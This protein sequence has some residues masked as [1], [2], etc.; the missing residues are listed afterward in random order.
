MTAS[1]RALLP[2]PAAA[3]LPLGSAG[4]DRSDALGVASARGIAVVEDV[5]SWGR[6]VSPLSEPEPAWAVAV[7]PRGT[8]VAAVAEGA[9]SPERAREQ[10]LARCRRGLQHARPSGLECALYSL[11]GALRFRRSGSGHPSVDVEL[12]PA[13]PARPFGAGDAL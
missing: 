9:D 1:A 4:D 6:L 12:R 2:L 8:G 11:D 5:R 10:A 3:L 13:A 7:G